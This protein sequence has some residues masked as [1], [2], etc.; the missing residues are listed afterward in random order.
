VDDW[1][2]VY[3]VLVRYAHAIDGRDYDAA[4]A[5]FAVDARATYGGHPLEPSRA[6]IVRFLRESVSSEASTHIVG[7]VR[8]DVDGDAARAEQTSFAVHLESGKVRLRGLRYRDRL[9]R[10]DGGWQ[11]VE[12][13]H[14]PVWTAEVPALA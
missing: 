4:G 5:C 3:D 11:I 8:I 6:A 7:G 1:H 10:R 13:V 9:E 14:E 12:R 2:A